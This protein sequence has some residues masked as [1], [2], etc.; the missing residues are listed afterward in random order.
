MIL[1]DLRGLFTYK[2]NLF[3]FVGIFKVVDLL[4]G[5]KVKY[6]YRVVLRTGDDKSVI[7]CESQRVNEI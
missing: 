7:M 4:F 5:V 2:T 6:F 1:S 3:T